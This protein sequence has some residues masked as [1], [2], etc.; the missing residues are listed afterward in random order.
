MWV[1]CEFNSV[2]TLGGTSPY[3]YSTIPA[4]AINEYNYN[5]TDNDPD[6]FSKTPIKTYRFV[7]EWGHLLA[8]EWNSANTSP[9]NEWHSGAQIKVSKK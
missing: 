9:T 5:L 1:G 8:L 6:T 4:Y 2:K 3:V 7:S